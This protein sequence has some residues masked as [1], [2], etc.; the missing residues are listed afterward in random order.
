MRGPGEHDGTVHDRQYLL[1]AFQCE[2]RVM[3]PLA[4]RWSRVDLSVA[5]GRDRRTI[6]SGSRLSY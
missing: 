3:P 5:N 2:D 4:G 6:K 1:N